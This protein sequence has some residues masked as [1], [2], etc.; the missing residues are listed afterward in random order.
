[1]LAAIAVAFALQGPPPPPVTRH[2]V[3]HAGGHAN[4]TVWNARLRS[5]S[6][7]RAGVAT[8]GDVHGAPKKT[9]LRITATTPG[10]TAITVGCDGGHQEVWLVDVR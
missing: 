10:S 2:Y 7:A 9:T 5:W 4:V 1:M 3:L 8:I 6:I